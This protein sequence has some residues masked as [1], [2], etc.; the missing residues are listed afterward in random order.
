MAAV[1]SMPLPPPPVGMVR[2]PPGAHGHPH[3]HPHPQMGGPPPM[4]IP[5]NPAMTALLD[6]LP[7]ESK[8][9]MIVEATIP[10]TNPPVQNTIVVCPAHKQSYCEACGVDF[11]SLNYTHQFMRGAPPEAIPPPPNVP[12]P[13]QRAEQIK[14]AKEQGN[15]GSC[16]L[17]LA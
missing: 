15:V 16:L 8:P 12:A 10:G 4:Q 11:N 2:P 7:H 6:A 9:L 14:N 3:P 5:V 13:P 1:G 17:T